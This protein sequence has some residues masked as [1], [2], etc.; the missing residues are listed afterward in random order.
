V[1]GAQAD[2]DVGSIWP[3]VRELEPARTPAAQTGVELVH[4]MGRQ[5][6]DL[7]QRAAGNRLEGQPAD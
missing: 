6:Q 2:L 3:S 5:L 7:G 4:Y 1:R